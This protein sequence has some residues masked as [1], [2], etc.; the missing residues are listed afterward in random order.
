LLDRSRSWVIAEAVRQFASN[1]AAE[2]R[3]PGTVREASA[4]YPARIAPGLGDYRL[5]QLEA[6]LQLTPEERVRA[7]EATGKLDR[8][9]R[10]IRGQQLLIFERPDDYLRWKQRESLAR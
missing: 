6:D 7:A 3:S 1:G 5:S 2:S 4:S 8:L 10:P 9:L